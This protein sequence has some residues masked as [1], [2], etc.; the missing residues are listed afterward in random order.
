MG[1]KHLDSIDMSVDNTGDVTQFVD[2]SGDAGKKTGFVVV[3]WASVTG[4]KDG[5]IALN[6]IE[7]ANTAQTSNHA[8]VTV[9]T[10]TISS[11]PGSHIF[12]LTEPVENVQLVYTKNN[13]TAGTMKITFYTNPVGR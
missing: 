13:I 4:T 2:E 3:S 11:T 8:A 5:T 1:Y 12:Y 10:V 6:V 9:E 7:P